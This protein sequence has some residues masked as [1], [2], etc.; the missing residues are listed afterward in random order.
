VY[1]ECRE[2]NFGRVEHLT[3]M[4]IHGTLHALGYDHENR[5]DASIMEKIEGKLLKSQNIDSPYN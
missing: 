1:A 5:K 3:H 4:L 2:N